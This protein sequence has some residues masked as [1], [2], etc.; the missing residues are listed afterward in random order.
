M[1]RFLLFTT[2][3]MALALPSM[4]QTT[5]NTP[6]SKEDVEKYLQLMHS[7][8]MFQQTIDAMSKPLHQMIHE[9]FQKDQDKLPADFEPRMNQIVDEMLR[10]LPYDQIQEKMVPVYQKHLTEGDLNALIAFY[11]SPTG[12]KMLKEMPTLMADTMQVTMPLIREHMEKVTQRMQDQI[13]QMK[14]SAKP[15]QARPVIEN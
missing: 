10:G 6:A 12:Q 7:R 4:A 9:E 15:G 14:K 5:D 1:K 3:C 11:S 8:E 13:A 2:L